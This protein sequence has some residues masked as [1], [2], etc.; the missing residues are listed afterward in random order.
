MYVYIMYN[1]VI[2]LAFA[3][4]PVH[5]NG[6]RTRPP[7]Q[8]QCSSGVVSQTPVLPYPIPIHGARSRECG[9]VQERLGPGPERIQHIKCRV[10]QPQKWVRLNSNQGKRIERVT[11]DLSRRPSEQQCCKQCIGASLRAPHKSATCRTIAP[12]V[13]PSENNSRMNNVPR[14]PRPSTTGSPPASQWSAPGSSQTQARNAQPPK[15]RMSES[16]SFEAPQLH[17]VYVLDYTTAPETEGCVSEIGR[18]LERSS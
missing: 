10:A 3:Y 14:P 12:M 17:K 9:V 2:L 13:A 7:N 11:N 4:Y 18:Q 16:M 1:P 5:E 6:Q 8:E 15:P